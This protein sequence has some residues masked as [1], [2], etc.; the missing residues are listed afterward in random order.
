MNCKL[1]ELGW[2]DMKL[3]F[4]LSHLQVALDAGSGGLQ[5]VFLQ[6]LPFS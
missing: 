2:Q 5:W 3:P 4:V 1:S 6:V